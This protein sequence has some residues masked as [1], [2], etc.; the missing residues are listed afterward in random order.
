MVWLRLIWDMAKSSR[1]FFMVEPGRL[2]RMISPAILRARTSLRLGDTV[3]MAAFL[4]LYLPS[5]LKYKTVSALGVVLFIV[6]G[7]V[8]VFVLVFVVLFVLFF[9]LLCFYVLVLKI[10]L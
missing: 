10:C 3:D 7:V 5:G 1:H 4:C 9:C 2:E 6:G 8:G